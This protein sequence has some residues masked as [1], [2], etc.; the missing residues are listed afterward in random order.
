MNYSLILYLDNKKK[1]LTLIHV[2]TLNTKK[3][4]KKIFSHIPN[5][6]TFSPNLLFLLV[7][8]HHLRLHP[9]Y[10]FFF[11]SIIVFSLLF[12]TLFL[13]SNAMNTINFTNWCIINHKKINSNIYILY[14]LSVI[15]S[16]HINLW[17]F[18]SRIYSYFNFEKFY[19]QNILTT[20]LQQIL[21]NRLLL[22]SKKVI[23]VVGWIWINNN[24]PLMIC[25]E[26]IVKILLIPF[27]F[28]AIQLVVPIS[29]T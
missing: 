20:L 23:S 12:T 6:I 28:M 5:H 7:L 22:V 24:L 19:V 16:C 21:S 25:Y 29:N 13:W 14:C 8:S 11:F 3:V 15:H 27:F 1:T 10:C 2:Q 26:S 17:A 4:G 18:H 9:F